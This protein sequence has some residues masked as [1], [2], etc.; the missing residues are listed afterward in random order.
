MEELTTRPII[1]TVAHYS[2]KLILSLYISYI[3][4]SYMILCIYNL[5]CY[6]SV[7]VF[8]LH[9]CCVLLCTLPTL[10]KMLSRHTVVCRMAQEAGAP[11]HEYINRK[12]ENTIFK[13][14]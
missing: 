8:L 5:I 12:K 9:D 10:W 3:V 1:S 7:I 13:P 6:Y 2:S 11:H 4:M 14:L